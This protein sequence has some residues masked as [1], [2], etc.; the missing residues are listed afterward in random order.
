MA[1]K[2][3]QDIEPSNGDGSG[4]RYI[5]PHC[6]DYQGKRS[7]VQ[8]HIRG[9]TDPVHKGL[10]GFE[11][12]SGPEQVSENDPA[13]RTEQNGTT[14]SPDSNREPE[15]ET[16]NQD[17]GVMAMVLAGTVLAVLWL[18]GQTGNDE[19]LDRFSSGDRDQPWEAGR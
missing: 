4:G 13:N 10:S 14:D 15:P 18:A 17:G 9:K 2:I 16:G 5:C 6:M 19:V 1:E 7:S 11:S 12:E 8:A 3:A